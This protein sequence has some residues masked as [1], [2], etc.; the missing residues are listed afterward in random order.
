MKTFVLLLGVALPLV[1]GQQGQQYSQEDQG[2]P[3]TQNFGQQQP[4]RPPPSPQGSHPQRTQGTELVSRASNLFANELYKQLSQGSG[5]VL[6]CP[7][8]LH[9]ALALVQTGAGS[10]TKSQLTQA[11]GF[12]DGIDVKKYYKS[13]L[14]AILNDQTV[15]KVATKMFPAKGYQLNEQ[16]QTNARDNFYAG[17]ENVDYNVPVEAAKTINDYV[18]K[19]TN[20]KITN[21]IS[22]DSLTSLT[23][24]II[25]N[26]VHFQ[27]NW[28]KPFPTSFDEDFFVNSQEKVRTRMMGQTDYF[29][30]KEDPALNAKV[31][32][33]DYDKAGFS[34]LI[35]LPNN[36]N[37]LSNVEAALSKMTVANLTN[38]L[39]EH[40]VEVIIP[41]FRLEQTLDLKDTL[42]KMKIVDMFSSKAD[43]KGIVKGDNV[44]VSS[45][46]QK[47]FIDVHEN[48]TEAAAATGVIAVTYSF[49]Q[50]E[51]FREDHPFV[52]YIISN[53][54][55][56]IL[57]N[58][59]LQQPE[60][61]K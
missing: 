53:E 29:M 18:E 28:K 2:S 55:K 51:Q 6:V 8:S 3:H 49:V 26:A 60:T 52:F 20:H 19:K 45:V 48:G 42:M 5:N 7:L 24:L 35:V 33:M 15:L 31:L 9:V 57:F 50:T 32:Q 36:A 46:V 11:L 44:Y 21:L 39:Q 16:F 25:I 34:M 27:S 61:K 10:T 12:S 58:G 4:S 13:T 54:N 40:K 23:R 37:E 43:L 59:R 47:T 17:I 41:K 22:P 30:F 56:V 14:D 38:G 1:L